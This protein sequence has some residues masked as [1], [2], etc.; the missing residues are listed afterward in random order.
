MGL[1]ADNVIAQQIA[2]LRSIISEAPSKVKIGIAEMDCAAD[3]QRNTVEFDE[4][5]GVRHGMISV[6]I[7][8]PD[9]RLAGGIRQNDYIDVK[10]FG[11]SN[12]VHYQVLDFTADAV[13]V[14]ASLTRTDSTQEN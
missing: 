9:V 13:C 11:E 1:I 8:F 7:P 3:I 2:D 10:M 6:L 14:Q 12:F 4:R 5:G